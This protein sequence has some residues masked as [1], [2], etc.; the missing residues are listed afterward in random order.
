MVD[1][2]SELLLM[3]EFTCATKVDS[4][5]SVLHWFAESADSGTGSLQLLQRN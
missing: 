2:I 3:T 4:A 5:T 1:D